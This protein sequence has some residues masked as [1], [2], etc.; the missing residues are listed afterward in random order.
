MNMHSEYDL[1]QAMALLSI[2]ATNEGIYIHQMGGFDT[3]EASRLFKIT[4]DYKVVVAFTI[5]YRGDA[6]TLPSKL[7]KLEQSPRLR[8]TVGESVF[9]GY[10]GQKADFL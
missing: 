3:S 5:G 9:T 8:R 10:F 6:E 4:E 2:Q 7:L 1:G